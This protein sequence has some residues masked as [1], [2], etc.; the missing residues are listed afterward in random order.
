MDN[1]ILSVEKDVQVFL[2]E[3]L[4]RSCDSWALIDA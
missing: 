4:T 1:V 2:L 3:S